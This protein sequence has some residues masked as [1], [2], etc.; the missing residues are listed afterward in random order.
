[1]LLLQ[2]ITAN[3]QI[4]KVIGQ[5]LEL[6][7]CHNCPDNCLWLHYGE[8][9]PQKWV[10]SDGTLLLPDDDWSVFG[11]FRGQCEDGTS[12]SYVITNPGEDQLNSQ[13]VSCPG[14][15]LFLS[16]EITCTRYWF[17]GKHSCVLDSCCV[18][19]SCSTKQQ[20]H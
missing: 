14:Q 5:V 11:T 12:V 18:C 8:I 7:P 20:H 3:R 2:L 10:Q 17:S 1:M 6:P 19:V 13:W 15:E 9:V 4:P 16:Q